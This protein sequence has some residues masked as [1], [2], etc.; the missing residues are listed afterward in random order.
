MIN[1]YFE[2]KTDLLSLP[3]R[4]VPPEA[5]R[6]VSINLSALKRHVVLLCPQK[7]QKLS[8]VIASG[9]VIPRILHKTKCSQVS[10]FMIQILGMYYMLILHQSNAEDS[11]MLI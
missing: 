11:K 2:I 5:G 10:R 9:H 8:A 4:G 3:L 1:N 7:N 6:G